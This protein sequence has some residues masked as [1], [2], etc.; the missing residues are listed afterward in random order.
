MWWSSSLPTE[1]QTDNQPPHKL[2][3]VRGLRHLQ[4]LIL[5]W[6][7]RVGKNAVLQLLEAQTGLNKVPMSEAVRGGSW[8]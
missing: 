2:Y 1:L 6:I 4:L 7:Y 3:S 5:Q 8:D